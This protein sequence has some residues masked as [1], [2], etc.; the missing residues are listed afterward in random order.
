MATDEE[1]AP[2]LSHVEPC[3]VVEIPRGN[4]QQQWKSTK[5]PVLSSDNVIISDNDGS[6]SEEV[7]ISQEPPPDPR[8]S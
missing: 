1:R 6:G 3:V 4:T 7:L 5:V 2:L 8:T